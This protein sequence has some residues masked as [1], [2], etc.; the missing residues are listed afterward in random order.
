[1]SNKLTSRLISI[2][3]PAVQTSLSDF[4]IFQPSYKPTLNISIHKEALEAGGTV[5]F[6]DRN[7]NPGRW[8][9]IN[10]SRRNFFF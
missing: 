3:S 1:M 10:S 6:I 2:R 7:R 8:D 5:K 9:D 4:S